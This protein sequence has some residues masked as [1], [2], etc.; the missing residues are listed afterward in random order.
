MEKI[1]EEFEAWCE[2]QED[3]PCEWFEQEPTLQSIIKKYR[4]VQYARTNWKKVWNAFAAAWDT[5][6]CF[7]WEEQ[8]KCIQ[9]CVLRYSTKR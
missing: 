1:W 8:Q 3:Y 6:K 5:A 7:E 2:S 4:P 9:K